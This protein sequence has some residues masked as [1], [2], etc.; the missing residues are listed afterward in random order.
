MWRLNSLIQF[1]IYIH[2][3][4]LIFKNNNVK[5]RTTSQILT[6]NSFSLFYIFFISSFSF[7]LSLFKFSCTMKHHT[8]NLYRI[9]HTL[10]FCFVRYYV[11]SE[12][13]IGGRFLEECFYCYSQQIISDVV[14][15][16]LIPYNLIKRAPATQN[17]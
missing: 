10:S 5:Y 12:I 3:C 4:L 9:S 1:I 14:N 7:L 13:R 17:L 11:V 15:V 8:Y 2:Y 16:S 6:L